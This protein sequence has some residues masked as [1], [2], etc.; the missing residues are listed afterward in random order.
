RRPRNGNEL[1]D[2]L[3]RIK[4]VPPEVRADETD[5]IKALEN[6]A[7]AEFLKSK[8]GHRVELWRKAASDESLAALHLC[9][10]AL[11]W[12]VGRAQNDEE[13]ENLFQKA[14]GLGYRFSQF[15]L[16]W[17]AMGNGAQKNDGQAEKWLTKAAVQGMAL[18]QYHL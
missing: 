11:K 9:A 7:C 13:A 1:H 6:G 18:A 2:S 8:D 10:E 14:A 12:G 16:G 15:R 4:I 5:Y 3:K 17:M